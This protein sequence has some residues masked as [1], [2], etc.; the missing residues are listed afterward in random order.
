MIFEIDSSVLFL[1]NELK[2]NILYAS[3]KVLSQHD[4]ISGPHFAPRCS[5]DTF[6]WFISSVGEALNILNHSRV[7]KF[8]FLQNQTT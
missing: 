5:I 1:K 7:I 3:P 4:I 6:N 2:S 8:K